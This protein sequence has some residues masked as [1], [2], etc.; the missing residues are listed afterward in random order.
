VGATISPT[1]GL[2]QA[3]L[4]KPPAAVPMRELSDLASKDVPPIHSQT[5]MGAAIIKSIDDFAK[6]GGLSPAQLAQLSRARDMIEAVVRLVASK[7]AM[8]AAQGA[9]NPATQPPQGMIPPPVAAPPGP[10][11]RA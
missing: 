8:G 6:S 5:A 7:P 11:A 3:D 1:T 2:G 9:A 4:Q 10:R